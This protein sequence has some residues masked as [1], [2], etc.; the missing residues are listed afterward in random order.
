MMK[1]DAFLAK[2]YWVTV[3]III[4]P[5]HNIGDIETYVFWIQ[6]EVYHQT[7]K[8][9]YSLYEG[10]VHAFDVSICYSSH[11]VVRVL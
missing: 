3:Y 6:T 7:D 11:D 10:V 8:T 4:K 2:N 9:K 5:D 1:S